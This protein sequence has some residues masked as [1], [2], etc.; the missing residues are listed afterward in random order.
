MRS[1]LSILKDKAQRIFNEY[2]RLRDQHLSCISCGSTTKLK[3]AGHYFGVKGNQMLR[4]DEDNVNGECQGCNAFNES[5]LIFYGDNLKL[6]IGEQRL[7]ELKQRAK[8]FKECP[9]LTWHIKDVEDIIE[10]Y[11]AKIKTLR[12]HTLSRT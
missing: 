6:K 8:A 4:Y 12:A 7:L 5:H 10:L 1:K 9:W 3:Q 11:T 2:I